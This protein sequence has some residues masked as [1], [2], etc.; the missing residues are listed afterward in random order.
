MPAANLRN[1]SFTGFTLTQ[2]FG[3]FNDNVFKQMILFF[4]VQVLAADRQGIATIFFSLPF[5]LFSGHAGQLAER[6]AKTEI[7]RYAKL[8]EL[9]I[10][11]LGTYAFFLHIEALLMGTL[12]L[13]GMHSAYFGPSKYGVIPELIEDKILINANGIIQM[14]TFLA[15]ILGQAFAGWLFD[16]YRERLYM[17]GLY[18]S[19]IAVLGILTVYM[20]RRTVA[21]RPDLRPSLNPFKAVFVTIGEMRQDTP[22]FLA[23]IAGCFFF[24]SGAIVTLLINNYGANLLGLTGKGTSILLV[25]LALGIMVGCLLAGPVQHRIGG[26][27]TIFAGGIGV[28]LSETALYF[29]EAPMGVIRGLLFSAGLFTGL[30]YV[31]IATFMQ[32]RPALGRK[33]EVLAAYNFTNFLAIFL[34]GGCWQLLVTLEVPVQYAWLGLSAMLASLIVVMFPQLR[35]IE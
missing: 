15:I 30:Y 1:R 2:F 19:V 11:L 8:A 35:R 13:M 4:T 7:M 33:G 26:K 5:I 24:F 25:L 3:A 9:A 14:T 6:Y 12:F 18:C 17:A 10:M 28:A 29:H 16:T 27:W 22:L 34:A 20:I 31:P 21:N 32:S 23:L